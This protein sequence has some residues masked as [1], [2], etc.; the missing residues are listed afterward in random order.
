MA[1][2]P[3]NILKTY[4]ETGDRPTE[5][6]FADLIDS[7]LHKDSGTVI[8]G[9]TF[10]NATGAVAIGFSDNTSLEFTVPQ[11]ADISFINGL[12]DALDGKVD[13]VA[14]FGLSSNDFSQYWINLINSLNQ[15][16]QD[17][18]NYDGE[19][20][21]A[22]SVWLGGGS[23]VDT[24]GWSV[25]EHL[26]NINPTFTVEKGQFVI[27]NYYV[28]ELSDGNRALTLK[29]TTFAP[30]SGTYGDGED[31]VAEN[32]AITS[33]NFHVDTRSVVLNDEFPF[34]G[35]NY[36]Q[37]QGGIPYGSFK[38][39]AYNKNLHNKLNTVNRSPIKPQAFLF[40]S[41]FSAQWNDVHPILFQNGEAFNIKSKI[42]V[43]DTPNATGG[44]SFIGQLDY[45]DP[46]NPN[47]IRGIYI[48]LIDGAG[49]DTYQLQVSLIEIESNVRYDTYDFTTTNAISQYW[50]GVFAQGNSGIDFEVDI[51]INDFAT[52][53]FTAVFVVN[54]E[55]LDL[56][57]GL[58]YDSTQ[59]PYSLVHYPQNN[60]LA[61]N[62]YFP[63]H[64][65]MDYF[66]Y[67]IDGEARRFEFNEP[68]NVVPLDK[69]GVQMNITPFNIGNRI[70]RATNGRFYIQTPSGDFKS[71]EFQNLCPKFGETNWLYV[72]RVNPIF[73]PNGKVIPDFSVKLRDGFLYMRGELE[74]TN[75]HNAGDVIYIMTLPLGMRP[76][77]FTRIDSRHEEGEGAA[78]LEFLT[79][80]VVQV[81]VL[82]TG[83]VENGTLCEF[84]PT[85][86]VL[87]EII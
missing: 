49:A 72:G 70:D 52:Q 69:N 44:W 31:N 45:E 81:R 15:F 48:G 62:N 1:K 60:R 34:L 85:L 74:F 7:F 64:F 50:D 14:G 2:K 19:L 33:D 79:N 77:D 12:Q 5:Q 61:W 76:K 9:W 13:K 43:L 38:Q 87:L 82:Q 73:Q 59:N 36:I 80:G 24:A 47:I 20:K 55:V 11:N 57:T 23:L 30:P 53:D 29:T 75:N 42:R 46:S 28:L 83:V 6:Q 8:T 10:N 18:G 41:N 16:A 67:T 22:V 68:D 84:Y 58:D 66:H 78:F 27:F 26:S 35:I 39:E 51:I 65:E 37:D 3:I 21:G 17:L 25:A 54:G 63:A 4:F 40:D 71:V 32:A 56:N 86:Q